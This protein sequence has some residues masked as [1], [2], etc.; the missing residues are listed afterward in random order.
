MTLYDD[1]VSDFRPVKQLA[2]ETL[3]SYQISKTLYEQKTVGTVAWKRQAQRFNVHKL[4]RRHVQFVGGRDRIV[5]IQLAPGCILELQLCNEMW[6]NLQH[7]ARDKKLTDFL[8]DKE[9]GK[10]CMAN[11]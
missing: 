6:R 10:R 2:T 3:L 8:F 9:R 11:E 7:Y 5:K 1:L 4:R